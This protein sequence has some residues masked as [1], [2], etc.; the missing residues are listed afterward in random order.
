MVSQCVGL[1][2]VLGLTLI[3][4]VLRCCGKFDG[5]LFIF[6]LSSC[7]LD[8]ALSCSRVGRSLVV[9]NCFVFVHR[10]YDPHD[11]GVWI[12]A[13]SSMYAFSGQ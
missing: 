12:L 13:R 1:L 8:G 6:V 9:S 3:S 4:R 5:L 11:G 7:G 10:K 2:V